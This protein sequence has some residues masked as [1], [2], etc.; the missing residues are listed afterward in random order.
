MRAAASPAPAYLQAFP[1]P[2]PLGGAEV[3]G[4]GGRAEP[5]AQRGRREST[6]G[7]WGARAGSRT[8][9]GPASPRL[10]SPR[11]PGARRRPRPRWGG[12][13]GGWMGAAVA[14]APGG[15][16]GAS[17]GA[18]YL[19][20]GLCLENWPAG[21]NGWERVPASMKGVMKHGFLQLAALTSQ[22]CRSFATH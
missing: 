8:L 21:N 6:G 1:S 7:L 16:P 11:E 18:G 9:G 15:A 19:P 5:A 12:W 2:A 4:G 10:A 22:Y 3:C 20:E 14:A 13:V 17:R